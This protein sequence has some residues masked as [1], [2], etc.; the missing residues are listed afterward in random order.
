M[1]DESLEEFYY[2]LL[3]L[4]EPWKVEQVIR[5]SKNLE[6]RVVVTREDT[7][8]GY[9]PNCGQ[10]LPVH[11]SR[12]RRWRHLDSCNHKTILEAEIPRV[13]CPEH[14]VH[15]VRLPWAE[16][17]SRFTLEFERQVCLWL[18]DAPISAVAFMFGLSWDAVSGIQGRAVKRGLQRRKKATPENIGIDETSYQ[19]HHEY[20]TVILDK[21][22][23]TVLDVLEDRTAETL[24]TWFKTQEMADFSA[25]QSVSMDMWDA[26]IKAVKA[27]IE[28]AENIIAF[29]RYHVAQHLSKAVDIVRAQEHREL[30]G[31]YG[32]SELKGTKYEWLRNSSNLDNR[33]GDRPAFLKLSRMDLK[34]A[35]A[36]RIKEAAG[37]LWDFVYEGVAE[38]RWKELLAWISRSK[39]EPVIKAGRMIKSYF[40]GILNAIRLKANNAM[41]ESMNSGI[42]RIKRMACGFRNR[43]RFRMAILFHFGG[44]EMGF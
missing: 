24:D 17:N 7:S 18:R 16:K 2:Q 29:D 21:D 13:N 36:W 9:C 38:K 15:Q 41:L 19:K 31:E 37:Q 14:G 30:M 39:L 8:V 34:T 35:R 26:F 22:N 32:V 28:G 1:S 11:D 20:V 5:D 10:E 23:N 42:Q 3:G 33:T 4:D 6:V 43:E 44:L 12:T 27:N 40:W 25:L